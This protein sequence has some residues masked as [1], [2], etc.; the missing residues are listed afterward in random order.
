MQVRA[1]EIAAVL[2]RQ[3]AGYEA[4]VDVAG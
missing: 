3:L 4:E 1:D 2:E